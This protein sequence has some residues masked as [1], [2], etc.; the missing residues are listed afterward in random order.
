MDAVA[1]V[2]RTGV[3]AVFG[4]LIGGYASYVWGKK[5]KI[6]EIRVK[7][8]LDL[9][10]R[11]SVTL[12]DVDRE[13][14]CLASWFESNFKLLETVAEGVRHFREGADTTYA[15]KLEY[16]EQLKK[17]KSELASLTKQAHL[18][19]PEA[20][21]NDL[22]AYIDIGRFDFSTVWPIFDTYL[23]QLF[24]NILDAEKRAARS[25][26]KEEIMKGLKKVRP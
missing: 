8:V 2:I 6:D 18:Y 25:R 3:T 23:E 26:L 16:I 19:L 22:T 5:A 24:A 9:L 11:L 4:S 10:E 13:T 15:G 12:Q 1:E 7:K 14:E 17:D 21:L 20:L